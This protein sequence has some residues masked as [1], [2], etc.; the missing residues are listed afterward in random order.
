MNTEFEIKFLGIDTSEIKT[1]LLRIWFECICEEYIMIRKTFHKPN[2]SPGEWFRVRKEK[3]KTTMTYK[4]ISE[5]SIDWVSE[6]EIEV[7]DLSKTTAI[8]ILAWLNNT[9]TQENKREIW[10]RKNVEIC[11]DT[12]PWLKTYIEIEGD[13]AEAVK[14][15]SEELGL[16]FSQWVFGWSESVYEIE[17][18][19]PKSFLVK[20]PEI[21]F[22][23]PPKYETIK[24]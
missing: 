12:W 7:S 19:I 17:L 9:S 8:L 1:K 3:N 2:P 18:W 20:L 14:T 23:N 24:S 15:V 21:S 11:F 22:S 5:N 4:N 10:S 16:D 6:I 13:S